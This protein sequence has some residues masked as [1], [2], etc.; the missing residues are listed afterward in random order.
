[1][2][3]DVLVAL[4]AK[5]VNELQTLTEGLDQMEAIPA[6]YLRLALDKSKALTTNIDNLINYLNNK[7]VED[8][9]EAQR[10][11]E[12]EAKKAEEAAREAELARIAEEQEAL[13]RAEELERERQAEA[14]RK[15]EEEMA[16]Q[17]AAIEAAR[18]ADLEERRRR[19]EEIRRQEE[20]KQQEEARRQA[21]EQEARRVEAERIAREQAEEQARIQAELEARIEAERLAK[22]QAEKQKAELEAQEKLAAQVVVDAVLAE[23]AVTTLADSIETTESLADKLAKGADDT[24]ASVINNKKIID[25]KASI[26]LGDRF[27]FQRELFGGNGERMNKA[28]SDFNSFESMDEAQAYIAKNFEWPLDNDAVSDF[29]QLLQRRYL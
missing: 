10:I 12:I 8:Q 21:A 28:I 2:N 5:D 6:P 20:L 23:S 17:V 1:M 18:Q 7:E 4:I 9:L 22:E 3:K 19:E 26:T 16:R 14:R 25:L 13:F 27:R 15:A 11:A 29:I 24:L